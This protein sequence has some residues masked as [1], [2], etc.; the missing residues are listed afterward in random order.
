MGVLNYI[1]KVEGVRTFYD[2]QFESL[3]NNWIRYAISCNVEELKLYIWEGEAEFLLNEFI[4][5]NSCFTD[6]RLSGCKLNPSGAIS[7]ENLRSLCISEVYLD[8]DLIAKS[9][10]KPILIILVQRSR[11]ARERLMKR[12]KRCL[13]DVRIM[14]LRHVKELQLGLLYSKV[15]SCLQAKGFL[16]PSNVKLTLVK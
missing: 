15:L 13:K 9:D 2:I 6:L 5:I 1:L 11:I 3:V 7:W 12:N 8:E 10:L 16:L 4:F 14:N